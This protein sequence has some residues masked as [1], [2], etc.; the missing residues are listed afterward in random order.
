LRL[1]LIELS[2]IQ[3][4]VNDQINEAAAPSETLVQLA[5]VKESDVHGM[6]SLLAGMDDDVAVYDSVRELLIEIRPEKLDSIE[7]CW[8]LTQC[9]YSIWLEHDYSAP[10]DL[11]AIGF[12]EDE[13]RMAA[14]GTFGSIGGWHIDFKSFVSSLSENS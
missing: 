5:Y 3:L 11:N 2:K 1:G 4:W 12:L 6:Y 10:E 13:Y 14:N 9:L 7:F 8:H